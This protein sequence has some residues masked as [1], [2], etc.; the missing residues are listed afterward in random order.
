MF[1]LAAL[2]LFLVCKLS[3]VFSKNETR[4]GTYN[5]DRSKTSISGISSGA[6]FAVQFH[7]AFSRT[8][9]GVGVTAGGPYYCARDNAWIGSTA[10]SIYPFLIRV[11][12]LVAITRTASL[13]G[14]IDPLDGMRGDK[15][16]LVSGKLDTVVR[17]GVVEKLFQYYKYFVDESGIATQFQIPAQ[18][19]MLTDD[20]GNL[21]FYLGEPFI[22]DCN[23]PAAYEILQHIYG[24][25]V[26][27][28]SSTARRENLLEFDQS[29]FFGRLAGL[30]KTGYL[31]VPSACQTKKKVCRL[32]IALHGCRMSREFIGRTFV[33]HAGYNPVAEVNN[34]IILYPQ[35]SRSLVNPQGCYDWWGYTNSDYGILRMFI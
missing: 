27:A 31:Y 15:I 18:H 9:M 17:Q 21:C 30:A 8:I 34:I 7:V 10:C 35:I 26:A 32:H 25:M 23:W 33:E 20:Y 29:E 22:N 6:Y 4:L 11:P 5:I 28:E 19:A 3:L 1:R 13:R 24:D 2:L 14:Y 16:L 12:R